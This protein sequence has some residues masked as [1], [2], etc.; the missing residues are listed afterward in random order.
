M[1]T[2]NQKSKKLFRASR[3]SFGDASVTYNGAELVGKHK[4]DLG[5]DVNFDWGNSSAGSEALAYA[6]LSKVGSQYMAH[7]Y[8][9]TYM[10]NVISSIQKDDWSMESI[11]VFQWINEN[12]NFSMD[13]SD[14][15]S[16]VSTYE[17]EERRQEDRR[18]EERRIKREQDFQE[19]IQK[20]L[21]EYEAE[22]EDRRHDDR[23][24]ND[25]RVTRDED[26]KE[27]L[28][29]AGVITADA[30]AKYKL[31]ISNYKQLVLN[32]KTEL[33]ACKLELQRY[34]LFVK[35]LDIKSMYEKYNELDN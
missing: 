20:R 16:G 28:D 17:Y 30:R 10:K 8:A 12:T 21:K 24:H 7:R 32:Q 33:E 3:G 23:R 4:S 34:K 15:E 14:F 1:E 11:E 31:E 5:S 25:R 19:K 35:S 22:N 2:N 13:Q 29:E 18:K 27:E 9:K 26:F 6:I